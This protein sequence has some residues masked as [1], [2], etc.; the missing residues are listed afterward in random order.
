MSTSPRMRPSVLWR[1][2]NLV[3]AVATY[4]AFDPDELR[5]IAAGMDDRAD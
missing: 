1:N 5:S 2:G 3:L 4:G